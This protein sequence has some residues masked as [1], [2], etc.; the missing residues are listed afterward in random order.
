MAIGHDYTGGV[1]SM[2]CLFSD[3]RGKQQNEEKSIKLKACK[4]LKTPTISHT[5]VST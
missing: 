1:L 4:F 5:Y 3:I 2:T